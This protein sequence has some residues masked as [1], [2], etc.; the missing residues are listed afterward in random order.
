MTRRDTALAALAWL[1]ALASASVAAQPAGLVV[2]GACRDGQPNGAYEL[3]SANGQVR[4]SGAYAKGHRTGT[5]LFW[6]AT[7]ARIALV[8]YD[9]DRRTG[10]VTLWFA[11]GDGRGEAQRRA[12]VAYVG[13]VLHGTTRSWYPNGNPRTELRFED[14]N[15]AEARAWIESGA[16]LAE[17]EARA[18]AE[19]DRVSDGGFVAGLEQ[20]AAEHR[21]R[22]APP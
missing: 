3:R 1:A 11:T 21:P 4:I 14:G 18:M 10:T 17:P 9:D 2:S 15:L 8:P 6:S 16:P 12:E 13:D 20:F 7:G 5:F 22:C 19:R